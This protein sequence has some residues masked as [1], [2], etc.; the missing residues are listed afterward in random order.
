LY[1]LQ[2]QIIKGKEL[3][4]DLQRD[5]P[6]SVTNNSLLSP[7][8]EEEEEV[9][10]GEQSTDE[11]EPPAPVIVHRAKSTSN[12]LELASSLQTQLSKF[13]HRLDD[14]RERLE[15]TSRC[16][17]L[18]DKVCHHQSVGNNEPARQMNGIS[19]E[20]LR[21]APFQSALYKYIYISLLFFGINF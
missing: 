20:N 17:E 7:T 14:T 6:A 13:G 8:Q 2:K 16:Y 19:I 12:I 4:E 3:L 11:T 9:A 18:L 15:D 10:A 1:H 5:S 21:D